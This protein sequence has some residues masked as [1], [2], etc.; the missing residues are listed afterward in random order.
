M[1]CIRHSCA[2]L[3]WKELAGAANQRLLEGQEGKVGRR[4]MIENR[5]R[6]RAI[7]SKYQLLKQITN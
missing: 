1:T 2:Y 4:S 3:G 7:L 6:R 5:A